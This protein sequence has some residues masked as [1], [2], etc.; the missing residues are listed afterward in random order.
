MSLSQMKFDKVWTNP[1]DFPTHETQESQVR[2]DMQYLFDSIKDQFNHFLANEFIAENLYFQATPGVIEETNVQA[3]IEYVFSQIQEAYSGSIPDGAV[4]TSKIADTAITTDKIANSA[5]TTDKIANG[6]VTGDKIAEGSVNGSSFADASIPAGKLAINSVGTNEIINNSV[7]KDKLA[8][9]SVITARIEDG[10]VTTAKIANANV[11]TAKI[12]DANVTTAKIKDGDVTEAKLATALAT[13]INGK[14][15][16]HS[17]ASTTLA[18]NTAASPTWTKTVSGVTSSNTVIVS[19]AGDST[20]FTQWTNSGI[21]VSSQGSN[22]LVFAARS[23]TSADCNV[24]IVI[25][26]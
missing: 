6:A 26:D 23:A 2:E 25:L 14:Q 4:S 7:T 5:V 21:R 22:Q 9:N 18:K 16:Q 17:T 1:V 12:A 15:K 20:S 10:A 8:N 3:A 24:N 19:P 11:T 13:K